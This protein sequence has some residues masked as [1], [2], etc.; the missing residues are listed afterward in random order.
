MKKITTLFFLIVSVHFIQSAAAQKRE[1]YQIRIY[2]IS[3]AEQEK[4]VDD[5]LKNAY[6]PALHRTGINTIGVFKPIENDTTYFGKRIYVLFPLTSLDQSVSLES[7]LTKDKVFQS[8]GKNYL[9]APYDK[10][11]YDRL[12]SILLQAF[13]GMPVLE[14]PSFTTP[15]TERIFE[16]R[17]YESHTEKIGKNKIHMFNEGDEIGLFKRLGFNAVFYGDVIAGSRMPNLMYMTSFSN[18]EAR[19]EHWK[20]FVADP[21]WKTL[22]S[23]PEYQHNVSKIEVFLLHPTDYSDL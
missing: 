7:A 5:F 20:A 12:Q 16:L 10:L 19:N 13:S 11:P 8:A 23:M 3:S 18:I 1:F 15:K 4:T 6:L 17:S 21:Q 2:T 9:E 14:K 22:S